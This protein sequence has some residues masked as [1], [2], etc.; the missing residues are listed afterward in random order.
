MVWRMGLWAARCIGA[1]LT[2]EGQKDCHIKCESDTLGEIQNI[3]APATISMAVGMNS[4]FSYAAVE[5]PDE[6]T[7]TLRLYFD[8]YIVYLPLE[9]IYAF[10][11]TFPA[12]LLLSVGFANFSA[13]LEMLQKLDPANYARAIPPLPVVE[14]LAEAW[15]HSSI[16]GLVSES[17]YEQWLAAAGGGDDAPKP[18]ETKKKEQR[19]YA[20]EDDAEYVFGELG[21]I[22]SSSYR[23]ATNEPE[24]RVSINTHFQHRLHD[25]HPEL[26]PLAR[27]V[28]GGASTTDS[29]TFG[30]ASAA[31]ATGASTRSNSVDSGHDSF[32]SQHGSP[33][34]HTSRSGEERQRGGSSTTVDT[35][36]DFSTAVPADPFAAEP[37]PEEAEE[38]G[39]DSSG[40]S[41]RPRL[42]T[43][44]RTWSDG[45]IELTGETDTEGVE[46]KELAHSTSSGA[47]KAVG[48]KAGDSD[49][50]VHTAMNEREFLLKVRTLHKRMLFWRRL[51]FAL[52]T[53]LIL[54]G[55]I[56]TLVFMG[57]VERRQQERWL[58]GCLEFVFLSALVTAP[59]ILLI[60]AFRR[61]RRV[62]R[63]RKKHTDE[64]W[65]DLVRATRKKAKVSLAAMTIGMLQ[66]EIGRALRMNFDIFII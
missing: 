50:P 48:D 57:S 62:R 38:Q 60:G 43:L 61:Q 64:E 44:T 24:R 45:R 54:G 7:N 22:S 5:N 66:M 53:C 15:A 14:P 58:K 16:G 34:S 36:I 13:R 55:W 21:I 56:I 3:Q 46:L 11:F 65:R 42:R 63:L 8:G 40:A 39:A 47:E 17:E 32:D 12:F 18:P 49:L 35:V 31:Y 2:G 26:L 33:G 51:S 1:H 23:A 10:L 37:L 27:D 28:G 20:P 25:L 30:S 9:G 29:T 4:V 6:A 52:A 41:A 19:R 59:L